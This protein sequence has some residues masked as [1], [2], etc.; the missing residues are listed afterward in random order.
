MAES[1]HITTNMVWVAMSFPKLMHCLDALTHQETMVICKEIYQNLAAISSPFG[2]NHSGYLG[3]MM[4]K[5][6][7]VQRFNDPFQPP[8]NLSGW[9]CLSPNSCAALMNR[10]TQKWRSSAKR[11]NKILLP[12]RLPSVLAMLDI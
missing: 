4:L 12:L 2:T 11:S 1:C 6:L 9:Q 8:I 3:I 5:A 10:H 7:Y